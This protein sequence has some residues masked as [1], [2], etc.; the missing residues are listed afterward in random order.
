MKL[1]DDILLS[2]DTAGAVA[3]GASLWWLLPSSLQADFC[4]D[5]YGI[6]ISVLSILFS[7]FAAALALI[8]TSPDDEFV[9]F[10]EEEGDYTFL[11]GTFRITLVSLFSALMVSL[12][13]YGATAFNLSAGV[14]KTQGKIWMVV[15]SAVSVYALLAAL[16]SMI[17]SI[18]YAEKRVGFLRESSSGDTKPD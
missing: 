11:V 9:R 8:M 5:L 18:R 4:K 10:M 15:F 12:V 6:G 3:I 13:W 7:L 1:V 17:D 14:Q 2:W 16:L